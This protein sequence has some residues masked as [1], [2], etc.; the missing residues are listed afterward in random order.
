MNVVVNRQPIVFK[1]GRR[2][3]THHP[4]NMFSEE[5]KEGNPGKSTFTQ[6]PTL[7]MDYALMHGDLGMFPQIVGD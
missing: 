4:R 5:G 6:V 1:V 7:L 3:C 2:K